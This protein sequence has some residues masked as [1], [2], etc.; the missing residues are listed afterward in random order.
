MVNGRSVLLASVALVQLAVDQE[1]AKYSRGRPD[2]T[3]GPA[4]DARL[5][6]VKDKDGAGLDDA[7]LLLLK[8]TADA[9]QETSATGL[10]DEE[11]VLSGLDVT[12]E[13]FYDA[14][15]VVFVGAWD[16]LTSRSRVYMVF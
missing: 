4:L 3:I 5:A 7:T 12:V 16:L 11:S 6:L 2:Q 15:G 8:A 13:C 10:K 1:V 9:R 14:H